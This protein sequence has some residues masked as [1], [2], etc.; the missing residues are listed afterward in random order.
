M[1]DKNGVAEVVAEAVDLALEEGQAVEGRQG[2]LL[3]GGGGAP[4]AAGRPAGSRNR[5]TEQMRRLMWAHRASTLPHAVQVLKEG[6]AFLRREFGLT[7]ADLAKEWRQWVLG[8]MPYEFSRMP[9]E[10][11]LESDQRIA[12]FLGER[13]EEDVSGEEEEANA[14]GSWGIDLNFG[15][16][17]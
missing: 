6:P 17:S 2:E 4:R 16:G 14:P 13:P 12:V 1:A 7:G 3:P 11:S 15:K 10:V 5:R 8:M 9:Q